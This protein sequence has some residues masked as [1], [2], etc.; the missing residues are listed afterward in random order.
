MHAKKRGELQ[1]KI[2]GEGKIRLRGEIK[3]RVLFPCRDELELASWHSSNKL[4]EAND[5]FTQSISNQP[6]AI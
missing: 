2:I 1:F 6:Q 4:K 5:I 3:P